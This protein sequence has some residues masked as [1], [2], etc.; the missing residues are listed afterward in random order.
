M[1]KRKSPILL[2][3]ALI[4]LVVGFTIV[5]SMV[6]KTV[7]QQGSFLQAPP[8]DSPTPQAEEPPKALENMPS[9]TSPQKT[10]SR[11]SIAELARE[12]ASTKAAEPPKP[13]AVAPPAPEKPTIQAP[14]SAQQGAPS[15][16]DV[17][18]QWFTPQGTLPPKKK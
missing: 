13:A 6:S 11:D 3:S 8:E 1:R 18:S 2:L 7:P 15:D 12:G 17:R 10:D 16:T 9:V 4:I 14:A 5:S